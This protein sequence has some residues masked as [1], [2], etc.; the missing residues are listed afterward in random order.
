MHF[1][2]S[3]FRRTLYEESH[4]WNHRN[5]VG[6]FRRTAAFPPLT[7]DLEANTPSLNA[8][9]PLRCH[10]V[11]FETSNPFSSECGINFSRPCK[12]Q[13]AK[14]AAEKKKETEMK[15]YSGLL[16]AVF[17]SQFMFYVKRHQTAQNGTKRRQTADLLFST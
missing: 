15:C 7:R 2:R 11:P 4:A 6:Y 16:C 8:N 1:S 5:L 17:H 10:S 9:E 14:N 13:S 3:A 12:L